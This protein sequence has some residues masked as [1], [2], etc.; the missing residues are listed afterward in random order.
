MLWGL[1]VTLLLLVLLLTRLS[2]FRRRQLARR[3]HTQILDQIRL[4]R[5]LLEQ[6]QRHRGLC[7]GSMS[8]EPGLEAQ[9]WSVSQQVDALL[10]QA[11]VHEASL[12]WY[13]GWHH[14]LAGWQ[15]VDAQREQASAEQV[16][17]LHNRMIA[18][19]LD[20]I[21]EMA[22]KQDLVC[23][24][25]LVPQTEGLW[26][27]L[28]QNAELLGQARAIGT[29]IA[30]RRQN[31]A[32]QRE[33]LQRLAEQIRL[34]AYGV[35]AR[36]YSDALLRTQ[37]AA[38]VREAE[39]SLDALLQLIEDLLESEKGPL[40]RAQNYFQTATRTISAQLALAD[41]LLERLQQNV[42]SPA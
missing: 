35:P 13:P 16:L 7:Y 3:Q 37:M 26:L 27:E 18:Q 6:L 14:V 4:L 39:D 15:E 1:L 23:L 40:V 29:G 34:R 32:L 2:Y 10:K 20:T 24:G 9:R 30:A 8:G 41:M 22:G 28:L 33:E 19:L 12:F 21:E 5:L 38:A 11:K 42:L 25:H 31:S 17:L 36:L